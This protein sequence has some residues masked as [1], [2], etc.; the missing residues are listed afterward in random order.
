MNTTDQSILLQ[1]NIRE[2]Y[3][4]DLVLQSENIKSDLL[5]AL[6]LPADLTKLHLI[7]E[8]RYINGI[9]ADFTLVYD[10]KIH[11]I[12]EVKAG[13]IGVTDY[14][15]GIGQVL[16]Y[17]Y[18]YENNISSKNYLFHENFASIFLIPSSIFKNKNFNVALFKYPESTKIIEI[19]NENKAVRE[20]SKDELAKLKEVEENNLTSIS[21][22][23]VRDTRLFE[24]YMLLRYLCFLKLK[25]ISTVNRKEIELQMQKT[26]S[27]N[28][29]N[30]RNV[31]ISLSS[32]GF[33]DSNN[34]PTKAG[35]EFGMMSVHEFLVMM[36]QSYVKPYA[37]ILMGYFAGNSNN[38]NNSLLSI[39]QDFLDMYGG[40][41][42]LFFTQSKT[43]YLSS[44]LNILRDDFGFI[45]FS[46]RSNNR[47]MN[48]N[49][50]ILNDG[51][52]L[53]EIQKYSKANQYVSNL[54]AIL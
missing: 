12:I 54:N 47:I 19:N 6:G 22:Y 53:K 26:N 4:H 49:P 8:D 35:A 3:F 32:F 29:R 1:G 5:S 38:L 42:I 24:I 37:D 52:L 46:P 7:H 25:G 34:M 14:V 27:I 40:K 17:E 16:Q 21:Q 31:W 36:Y 28:N 20:I 30:W 23:Y 43:R 51:F 13:D 33:I 9:I 11:A 44:W 48:F 45:D 41:E 18:F 15:R 10:D 39:K 2:R 50:L